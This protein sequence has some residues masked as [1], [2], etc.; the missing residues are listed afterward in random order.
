MSIKTVL[1]LSLMDINI[2]IVDWQLRNRSVVINYKIKVIE[3]WGLTHSSYPR[4]KEN[5]D[6]EVHF[7][8]EV[9]L[10]KNSSSRVKRSKNGIAEQGYVINIQDLVLNTTLV[11]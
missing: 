8:M 1:T 2:I 7:E 6:Y 3:I 10:E 5:G 11:K 9:S 4:W